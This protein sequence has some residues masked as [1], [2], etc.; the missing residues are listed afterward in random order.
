VG[1]L[2]CPLIEFSVGEAVFATRQCQ[3]LRKSLGMSLEGFMNKRL[4]HARRL[5]ADQYH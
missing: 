1:E 4:T 5:L 2:I 3:S